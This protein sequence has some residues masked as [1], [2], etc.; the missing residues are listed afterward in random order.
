MQEIFYFYRY[1]KRKHGKTGE[2]Q[3]LYYAFMDLT[4][5]F[6][7]VSREKLFK[8]LWFLGVQGK[9]YRVI[10]DLYTNNKAKIR[11]GEHTSESLRIKSGVIQ[12]S[13]LRPMLFN[14]F[15]NDLLKELDDSK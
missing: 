11:F 9:M 2:N 12:G 10:K 13:K 15:I 4:K 8:K 7:T 6:D 5:A 3:L 1:K 14:V